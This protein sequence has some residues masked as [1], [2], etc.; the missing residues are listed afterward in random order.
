MEGKYRG[1]SGY[2]AKVLYSLERLLGFFLP[3]DVI[4]GDLGIGC[5][6]NFGRYHFRQFRINT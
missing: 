1:Y 2:L 4:E 3:D 5:I 6:N